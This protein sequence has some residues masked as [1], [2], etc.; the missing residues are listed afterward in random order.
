MPIRNG[1]LRSNQRCGMSKT[2]IQNFKNILGVR[3]CDGITHPVVDDQEIDLCQ[4]SQQRG[5]GTIGASQGQ[6]VKQAR[7]ALIADSEAMTRSHIAECRGDKRFSAAG[8]T[9]YQ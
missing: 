5:E 7:G 2:V 9:Q 6:R 8:R 3:E 1:D 4:R